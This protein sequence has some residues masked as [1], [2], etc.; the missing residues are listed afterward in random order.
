MEEIQHYKKSLERIMRKEFL[1][2]AILCLRIGITYRT[3]QN[4]FDDKFD[5][6]QPKTLRKIKEFVDDYNKEHNGNR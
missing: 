1:T 6:M 2:K 5:E 4:L 3:L